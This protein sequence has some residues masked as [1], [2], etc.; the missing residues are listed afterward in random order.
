MRTAL[1]LVAASSL[2]LSTGAR[3]EKWGQG[4]EKLIAGQRQGK[5][6]FCVGTF[7][8][9]SQEQKQYAAAMK[10]TIEFIFDNQRSEYGHFQVRVGEKVYHLYGTRRS[11]AMPFKDYDMFGNPQVGA[12]FPVSEETLRAAQDAM[13]KAA[14]GAKRN[15]FPH[16][17]INSKTPLLVKVPGKHTWMNV[18]TQRADNKVIAQLRKIDGKVYMVGDNGYRQEAR[19]E[20]RKGVRIECKTCTSF[21]TDP[22]FE[23]AFKDLPQVKTFIARGLA[24]QL[25][26]EGA[27]KGQVQPAAFTYYH[28]E[29][30]NPENLHAAFADALR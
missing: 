21:V 14:L 23:L 7:G 2:L 17:S 9:R 16:F 10:N 12:V 26:T 18:E 5:P 29:D 1:L 13:D 24:G 11:E 28:P 4:V 8:R 3:A 6:V 25:F 20:R 30:K 27:L 22:L 15:S 19:V